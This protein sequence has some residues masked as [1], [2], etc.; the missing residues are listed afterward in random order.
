M[1]RWRFWVELFDRREA[2]T[3]LAAVRI[4]VGLCTLLTLA[5]AAADG[6][7]EVLWVD[8]AYGGFGDISGNG[9]FQLC[10]GPRPAVTWTLFALAASG[11]LL[12]TVGLGARVAALVTTLCFGALV[13]SQPDTTGGADAL[14]TN[15]L[16]LLALSRCDE[17]LSL[18][19]RLRAG[20][21]RSDR[22]IPA[23]PRYLLILQLVVVYFAAGVQKTAGVWTPGGGYLALH[24]VFQDPTWIRFGDD[25]LLWAS[26]LTRIGTAVTWHW[27]HLAP[28]LLLYYYFAY[29]RER[30]GRIR[31][32]L[33]RFD[34]RK[35]WA[36]IGVVLHVGIFSLL[37]VGVFS[38]IAL[39]YYFALWRPGEIERG[40]NRLRERL[41]RLWRRDRLVAP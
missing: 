29:T 22:E 28:L 8:A 25:A 9:F 36:A 37:D 38:L 26:P 10:G 30:S 7:V 5:T 2:G 16:W 39:I 27:E 11:A 14:I 35:P 12:V 1:S 23:W 31:R 17:T 24:Y 19:C 20:S 41:R 33:T 3:S 18:R 40:A 34:L 4:G 21:F 6:M 32:W 15:A 13:S